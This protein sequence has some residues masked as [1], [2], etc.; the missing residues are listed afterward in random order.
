M[1]SMFNFKD[2]T[3][4]ISESIEVIKGEGD[5]IWFKG[6]D[7]AR[8]LGYIK[9]DDAIKKHVKEKHKKMR[10][11]LNQSFDKTA[12]FDPAVCGVRN[13]SSKTIFVTES[14]LYS[15]IMR[16][17]LPHA[18]EFQEWV[19]SDV[20]PSIRQTGK[21]DIKESTKPMPKLMSDIN[22]FM[23]DNCVYLIDLGDNEYKFGITGDIVKRLAAHKKEFQY[24]NVVNVYKLP[25]INKCKNVE[26]KI[27]NQIKFLDVAIK[28]GTQTELFKTNEICSIEYMLSLFDKYVKQELESD[29]NIEP[30]SYADS[31][32]QELDLEKYKIDVQSKL[33]LEK[34]KL[35]KEY[36]LEKYKIDKQCD[37]T[38]QTNQTN[39]QIQITP[40]SIINNIEQQDKANISKQI[41]ERVVSNINTKLSISEK[42]SDE[43][44]S[45]SNIEI[46]VKDNINI[47]INEGITN[48][49]LSINVKTVPNTNMKVIKC[50]C[51]SFKSVVSDK[52][53]QCE[54]LVLYESLMEHGKHINTRPSDEQ[55]KKDTKQLPTIWIAK[56]YGVSDNA[57]R[58]WVKRMN[59]KDPK[60]VI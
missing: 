24:K 9:T 5:Q 18:E 2:S 17:K 28:K 30:L 52:C 38:N 21:Y 34:Y 51:G 58:K 25:N 23:N 4:K 57:V 10:Y 56:R 13:N 15:L 36:E 41:N 33:E 46:S 37:T 6:A 39:Q 47:N 49:D 48:N 50:P 3:N 35:D 32:L 14:G 29:D 12:D 26:D 11:L 43:D 53:K 59:K 42:S 54:R 31:G 7:V 22:V 1:L 27:K 40:T 55:L 20:L 60:P 45:M 8:A 44:K 19:T 16:S